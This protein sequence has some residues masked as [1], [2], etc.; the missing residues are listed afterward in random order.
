MGD[1]HISLL[2]A[3]IAALIN[4]ALAARCGKV[5]VASGMS[6]G[7][8]GH[9]LLLKRMRAQ[10]NFVEYTPLALILILALELTGNGG[11]L[12]ALSAAVFMLGR[13][14]HAAGMDGDKPNKLRMFG[15]LMTLPLLLGWAIAAGLVAFRVI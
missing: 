4:I 13:V 3:G 10:A 1:L 14:L 5:R 15:M 6:H 12:L 2:S 11:W 9:P 8:G 7:D